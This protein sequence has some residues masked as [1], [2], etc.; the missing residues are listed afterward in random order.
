MK[1]LVTVRSY[2]TTA[3]YSSV[4]VEAIDEAEAM[5]RAEEACKNGLVTDWKDAY[6]ESVEFVVRVDDVEEVKP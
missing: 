1:Y 3:W 2:R 4:D 5:D 6:D